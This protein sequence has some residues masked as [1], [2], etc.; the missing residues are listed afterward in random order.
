MTERLPLDGIRVLDLGT[1][2]AA[3]FAATLLAEFG[4]EVI[5]VEL[6]GSGD[7]LRHIGPFEGGYSLWW[8][9]ENRGKKSITLDLR[10]PQGREIF[11]RLVPKVDVIVENFQPGTLEGWG[12]DFAT[13]RQFNPNIILARVSVYGQSGPYARRPGLDRIG[14]A[15]GGL[16]YLTGYPDRPPVRPGIL[17]ADY[18]TAVFNAF[19]ILLALLHRQRGGSGQWIDLALYESVFRVLEYTV[20]AYDRLGAVREREGNRLRNSAPLDNWET[21]DRQFVCIVAAGDVLFRRLVGA[22][23]RPELAE[24]PRFATLEARV[25]HADEIHAIVG[26]WVRQHTAAEIENILVAA[27]VPVSRVYSIADIFADP[28]YVARGNIVSVSDPVLGS[29]R[30][31]G[32]YPRLSETPGRIASG[33]PRLGEHNEEIYGG[34]LGLSSREQERLRELGVI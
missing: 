3:P 24:D 10:K 6:P 7:F 14:I 23:G 2:I 29:I 21:K 27:E 22:M 28:H 18:L 32:V 11:L 5:K 30:M 15:F 12:L 19:A 26:D 20:A 34:W 8:A 9:V 33:A 31:Q 4:A 17:V 13:L 16:L 25:A 1:R